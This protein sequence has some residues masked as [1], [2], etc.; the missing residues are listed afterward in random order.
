MENITVA[1]ADNLIDK[2]MLF[3]IIYS[4]I[5]ENDYSEDLKLKIITAISS[6]I[7]ENEIEKLNEGLDF[8]MDLL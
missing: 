7:P 4:I 3:G 2:E 1:V 8:Y 6:I 5:N